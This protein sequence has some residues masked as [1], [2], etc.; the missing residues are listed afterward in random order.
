MRQLVRLVELCTH[1]ED[2]LKD[3]DQGEGLSPEAVSELHMATDLVLCATE[4]A[5]MLV[6]ERH[7][8]PYLS[9]IKESDK[10]VP[11]GALWHC[12]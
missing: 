6:M 1:Q 10:A 5:A 12:H 4:Q 3:L 11:I 8:W 9:G 2:L 7:L